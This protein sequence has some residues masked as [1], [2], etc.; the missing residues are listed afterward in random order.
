VRKRGKLGASGVGLVG[1]AKA[2]A[3]GAAAPAAAA[4]ATASG[5]PLPPDAAITALSLR[6]RA[7]ANGLLSSLRATLANTHAVNARVDARLLAGT[8]AELASAAVPAAPGGV[9]GVGVARAASTLGETGSSGTPT[10]AGGGA[11]GRDD[12][13]GGVPLAVSHAEFDAFVAELEGAAAQ[14]A[15]LLA[16]LQEELAAARASLVVGDADTDV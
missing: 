3:A 16:A 1:R 9:A 15:A 5:A 13:G 11:G 7:Y 8:A 4:A 10:H 12:D 6:A 14:H 2:P